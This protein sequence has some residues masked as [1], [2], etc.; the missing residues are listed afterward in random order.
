M[1]I[2]ILNQRPPCKKCGG[3]AMVFVNN[4]WLCGNCV[5]ILN[6]KVNKLKQRLLMEEGFGD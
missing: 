2:K 1:R 4:M 5:I 3:E 6:E